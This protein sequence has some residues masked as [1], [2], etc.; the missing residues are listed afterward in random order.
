MVSRL[1]KINAPYLFIQGLTDSHQLQ[2]IANLCGSISPEVWS[3][4]ENFE[5]YSKYS[6][7]FKEQKRKIYDR[8]SRKIND[9]PTLD[10]IDKLLT[11]DPKFRLLS[12]NVLNHEFFSSEPPPY[13]CERT[14][15]RLPDNCF[16][17]T[18]SSRPR[19]AMGNP[20]SMRPPVPQTGVNISMGDRLY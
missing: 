1:D 6:G 17:M 2:L 12:S 14:L 4:V 11:L 16:E 10:L 9:N 8:L 13:S 19:S 18:V 7:Q 3:D 20:I 5:F 15:S